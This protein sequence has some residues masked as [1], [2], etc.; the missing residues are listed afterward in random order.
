[1]NDTTYSAWNPGI[2]TK[3]PQAYRSIETIFHPDLVFT[4]ADEVDELSRETG[5]KQ[6]ELVS[7]RPHRLALHELIIRVNADILVLEGKNEEDLGINFRNIANTINDH[8]LQDKL[9]EIENTYFFMAEDVEKKVQIE[10]EKLL[11]PTTVQPVKKG[12]VLAKFFVKKKPVQTIQTI[13]E[14]E[15]ALI[16]SLKQ[17]QQD[18]DNAMDYVIY[19][20]L[21]RVLG[22]ISTKRGFI[23]NDIAYLSGICS[24]HACNYLGSELIGKIVGK[25]VQRAIEKE[26][27][28][29]IIDTDKA[30]LISLK[31]A[32]A[33]GKS[34]LRP[35]LQKMMQ[36]LCIESH[37]YGTIS[38][39]IWRKLLLDYESLGESYK[40]AGRFA[41][42]EISIIDSKLDNYRRIKAERSN[43]GPN[44][45]VDR[46]RFDSFASEKVTRLLH[47][48]YI[49]YLD[50]VYMFFIVTPPE[51]T[52]ERGWERGLERG[53]YK[54]VEDFLGHCVEAYAGMSK[55]LF[56]WLSNTEPKFFFEFLDN[57]VEK[58]TYPRMI[59]KG[60]QGYMAIYR[61]ELFVNIERY[62]HI[63]VMAKN[64]ETVY[65][66]SGIMA[67]Q[68]NLGF[69]FQ[70]IEK[71][72]HLDFIDP[73]TNTCYL[74]VLDGVFQIKNQAIFDNQIDDVTFLLI[75]AEIAPDLLPDI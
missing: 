51:A 57:S 24:R 15:Y 42:H 22:S 6:K 21:H 46:F 14:R 13:E 72:N 43:T 50:R 12:R 49:R 18:C 3:I 58:G 63:N 25:K 35:T 36:E 40:Y 27:Y 23:G 37:G 45:V 19:Q 39:D 68:N 20:S 66:G 16:N 10:L 65:P 62:Q 11:S 30:V 34:S 47:K 9:P 1:M 60:T 53:R 5:L 17:R 41:S 44:L 71:I 59:A 26:G 61:A 54:S 32:S 38:P 74:S 73:D 4:S 2:E 67:V 7:F 69:L 75:I 8:Y 29:L 56:K 33:A 64:P 55:L 48:T 31:G 52:V 28:P 70:C